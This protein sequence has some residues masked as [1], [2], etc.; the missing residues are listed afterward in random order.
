VCC[1]YYYDDDTLRIAAE[2]LK[3][4][5]KGGTVDRRFKRDVLPS[6]QAPVIFMNRGQAEPGEI[7]WGYPGRSGKGLVINTRSETVLDRTM[8]RRGFL[9]GR[10]LIP[11]S[12]FYEWNREK[13]KFSFSR[14]DGGILYLAG[15]SDFFGSER[16]FSILTTAANESMSSVHDRMPLILE[17]GQTQA[18][19]SDREAAEELLKNM[20]SELLAKPEKPH[21][22]P[23]VT[24]HQ[25]SLF[26]RG[27]SH[28]NMLACSYGDAREGQIPRPLGRSNSITY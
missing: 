17:E 8:F 4:Y 28:A 21:K 2:N 7:A 12:G 27:T 25:M 14:E 16:R 3:I 9:Y 1:R 6:Q 26:P 13:E 24:Y 19:L 10:I 18:W 23:E 11:A 20:P 15:I 5:R 22:E